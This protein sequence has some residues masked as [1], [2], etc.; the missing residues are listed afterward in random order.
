MIYQAIDPWT[1]ILL[2]WGAKKE[3]KKTKHIPYA[4]KYFIVSQQLY[5]LPPPLFFLQG[6]SAKILS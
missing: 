1:T 5:T 3:N 4:V 2:E 6:T